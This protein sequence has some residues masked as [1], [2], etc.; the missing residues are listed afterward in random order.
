MMDVATQEL[1]V[2]P[3]DGRIVQLTSESLRAAL[4][5][6]RCERRCARVLHFPAGEG[7]CRIEQSARRLRLPP[8]W[9]S[10]ALVRAVVRHNFRAGPLRHVG[11]ATDVFFLSNCRLQLNN[12]SAHDCLRER[13]SKRHSALASRS[14]EVC[15]R[16][17]VCLPVLVC[18]CVCITKLL[19]VE[20]S[21]R[22]R[23]STRGTAREDERGRENVELLC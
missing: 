16:A 9:T 13:E 3:A 1:C 6:D 19:G 17:C 15:V 4:A 14:T 22:E 5:C 10:C 2:C 23:E 12:N 20:R 7:M 11:S 21:E 8:K 18:A